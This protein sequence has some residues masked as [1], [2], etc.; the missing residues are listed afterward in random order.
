MATLRDLAQGS[1]RLIEELGAGDTASAESCADFL[2]AFNAM[3]SSW[4]IQGDLVYTKTIETFTLTGNDGIY[5]LGPTGDFVTTRPT[6][7]LAVTITD[8]TTDSPLTMYSMEQYA[9]IADKTIQGI[10]DS[11][12][13]DYNYPNLGFR[14]HTV[15]GQSY[16]LT[17]YSE[18]PLSEYSAIGDTLIAP[19][20]YERAFRYNGA[21][22]IAPEYGK[23]ASADVRRIAIE[24][25]SAIR[26]QNNRTD[27][28]KIMVDDALQAS[29][30]FNIYTGRY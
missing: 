5:T 21:V 4:S 18:K 1:L 26:N 8:D 11:I 20:G 3:L 13:I 29:A 12:Y 7:I 2:T 17:F 25:K 30:G 28:D 9:S 16:T 24:S 19:P 27:N 23:A 22:E 14:L 6:R 15:P 10:P